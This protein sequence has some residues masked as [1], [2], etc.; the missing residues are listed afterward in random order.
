MKAVKII[1][2][3]FL[4]TTLA[5]AGTLDDAPFKVVLTNTHWKLDDSNAQD[6]S[7]GVFLVASIINPNTQS[8]SV[9]IK[10]VLEK[11]SATSLDELAAGIEDQFSNPIVKKLSDE[12]ATFLGYKARHFVYLVNGASY[13]EAVVFVSGNKGWTIAVSGLLKQKVEIQELL[14]FYKNKT[15]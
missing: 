9:I 11:P 1:F 7:K 14:S 3:S 5:V 4:A 2:L 10:T 15:N 8:K 12:P 13:N 6:L